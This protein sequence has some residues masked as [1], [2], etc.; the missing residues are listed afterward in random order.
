MNNKIHEKSKQ[1][2]LQELNEL[3]NKYDALE[4]LYHKKI[5]ESRQTERTLQENQANIKAI[6]ENSLD[7]V[8]SIDLNYNIQYINKVFAASFKQTFGVQLEKGVNILNSLPQNLRSI[9]KERYDRA[10]NK[11]HFVFT[12]KIDL[13][14]NSVFIEVSMNPVVSDGKV[15]G[16]S[17]FGKDI[18][19]RKST[20][21]ALLESE[22]RFKAL[23]NASFGGIVI[24]DKGKILDCNQ[25]LATM[26]GYS[27]EELIGMDGFVLFAESSHEIARSKM[28]SGD[29]KPY[30]AIGKRKNGEEF[31]LRLE[32]RNVPYK[33]RIVRTTEF[34]DITEQKQA[35]KSLKERDE[36][37]RHF[38]ENSPVYVFF[39]DTEIRA[40]QL[41]KNYENLLGLPL[42]QIIGKSMDELFP[43]DFAKNMIA[44]DIKVMQE[45][46]LKVV[47]E[48]LNGRFY[49]TIKFPIIIDGKPAYLAGYTI[50]NTE[51]RRAEDTLKSSEERLKIL[52]NYA[53]EGYYLLDLSGKF[54]DGN[55]AA[56]KLIGYDKCELIGKSFF[57]LNL[58]PPKYLTV[59]AEI[60][61][62]GIEGNPTGPEELMLI[63]KDGE[64]V[65]VEI[66]THPVEIEGQ[67]LILGIV[68]DISERKRAEIVM[69]QASENWNRTFQTMHSGIA[70]LDADQKIIQSNRAF[71]NFLNEKETLLIGKYCFPLIL[72]NDYSAEN[73]P[74]EKIKISKSCETTE[75]SINGRTYEILVDPVLDNDNLITGSVLVMNDITQK[76]RD[77]NIQQILHEITGSDLL[78]KSIEELLSIVRNELGKVIDVTNFF[79]A[80]HNPESD[81]LRKVIFEDE[82]DDFLEWDA[83]KSLSGHVLKLGK[84][85]LLNSEEEARF[86]AENNIELLGSPAACW[87]GVPL[88][89]GEKTIGVMVVQ[90]YTDENAYDL[91]TKRLLILIAHELS[92]VV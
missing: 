88:L 59:A 26:T 48:E 31:P 45:G 42:D 78:D 33:G 70:L 74:F 81:T 72:N 52:F 21:K 2:L 41:S 8:W 80:L 27:P 3:K 23:H 7:S 69:K 1:E 22:T 71:Q 39:K 6:I 75:S 85:L 13:G 83:G 61:K 19:E 57:E 28:L 43:S 32:A 54:V 38:M 65:T 24:H 63:R 86:A 30:E 17:F 10:F 55:I 89:S 51:H 9:W 60:L 18:S 37:F 62:K 87:L 76:K 67:T 56:E 49:T 36:I 29:E 84:P 16:A 91:A 82:K 11:E 20:E 4:E 12:D 44:D 79:V 77:E 64:I 14:N 15:V 46:K 92:I 40:I 90:S 66:A 47:E 53:P 25:G 50:D 5:E 68:R 58:L 34:R 35:E 73:N